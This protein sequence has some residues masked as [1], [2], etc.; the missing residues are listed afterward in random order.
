MSKFSKLCLA[1]IAVISAAS[2]HAFASD[3]EIAPMV[4]NGEPTELADVPW[5]VKLTSIWEDSNYN[6]KGSLC[7]GSI[8][9]DS[10][11][12]TAA[13]CFKPPEAGFALREVRVTYY[14]DSNPFG[15]SIITLQPDKVV[16]HERWAGEI[17]NAY[18]IAYLH[19]PLNRFAASK[20]I[21]VA[22]AS[23]FDDMWYQ[24]ESTYVPNQDNDPNLLTSGYGFDENGELENLNKVMVTGLDASSCSS[25]TGFNGDLSKETICVKSYDFNYN[26]SIC[27]GDSGGPLVWQNPNHS[28]DEDYG[29][30]LV[31]ITSYVTVDQNDK[32]MMHFNGYAGYTSIDHYKD[33]LNDSVFDKTGIQFDVES[34]NANYEFDINPIDG[35]NIEGGSD[36]DL[37]VTVEAKSGGSAGALSLGGLL[38]L[39]ASRR[40]KKGK[41]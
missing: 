27:Q 30:R 14:S 17:A 36:K 40:R 25:L 35:I 21:K 3:L 31:G 1:S 23:E 2:S 37:T 26:M 38:L 7:G 20:K 39:G 11:V 18:D 13:H 19:D 10:V 33:W 8:V 29:L 5:Q 16:G 34:I 28:S 6:L 24:F 15:A 12:L 32:C 9:S 4:M 22:S 41:K